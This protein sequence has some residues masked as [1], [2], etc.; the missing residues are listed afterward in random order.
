MSKASPIAFIQARELL[1]DDRTRP[2]SENVEAKGQALERGGFRLEY[3]EYK[4]TVRGELPRGMSERTPVCGTSGAV[5]AAYWHL[6][7]KAFPN[8]DVPKALIPYSRRWHKTMTMG[9][10]RDLHRADQ[11]AGRS[12]ELFVKPVP[13][14][15]FNGFKYNSASYIPGHMAYLR[16]DFP[17][18]VQQVVDAY[19]HDETRF[20]VLDG[21]VLSLSEASE[22]KG[23]SYYG[24]TRPM[25]RAAQAMATAWTDAPRAYAMDLVQFPLCTKDPLD[26]NGLGLVEVNSILTCGDDGF[27]PAPKWRARLIRAAWESYVTYAST[28]R[29]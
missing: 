14:K 7:G 3:F 15:V 8:I 4:A 10:L 24:K 19:W 28:N 21:K 25:Y 11:M 23:S 16:D 2:F 1:G 20:F 17:L 29:F 18:R 6:F 9:E 12:T 22:T 5:G 13:A 27:T 26:L